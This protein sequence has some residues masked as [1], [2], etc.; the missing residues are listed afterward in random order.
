MAKIYHKRNNYPYGKFVT[1]TS[2]RPSER[3]SPGWAG[4][5]LDALFLVLCFGT[6]ERYRERLSLAHTNG[7]IQ[8]RTFL[9][10]MAGTLQDFDR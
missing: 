6:H 4:R 9:K 5:I 7:G 8:V 1:D 3:P 10:V 2:I